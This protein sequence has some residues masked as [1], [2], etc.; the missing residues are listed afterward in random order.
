VLEN[1]SVTLLLDVLE[2]L[3]CR[4][5]R[6]IPLTHIAE[7]TRELGQ[8]LAVSAFAEP[9]DSQVVRFD[10]GRAREESEAWLRVNQRSSRWTV[11]GGGRAAES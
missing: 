8:L 10:E 5:A 7:A 11:R 1:A 4:S 3:A 6:R 2:V 9:V